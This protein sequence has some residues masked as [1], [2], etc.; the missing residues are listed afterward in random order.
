MNCGAQFGGGSGLLVKTKGLNN[1]MS[2]P[3]MEK[4]SETFVNVKKKV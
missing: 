4:K 3:S 2:H 1:S